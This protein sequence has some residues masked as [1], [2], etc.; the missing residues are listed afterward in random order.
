LDSHPSGSARQIATSLAKSE[1]GKSTSGSTI[2]EYVILFIKNEHDFIRK[3]HI[4][5]PKCSHCKR[6]THLE[7]KCT[8]SNEKVFCSRC[9]IT[10]VHGCGR[11]YKLAELVKVVPQKVEKI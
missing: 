2:T 7:F 3:E 1:S 8:C 5:M 10:E 9:H 11:V 6:K 4:T